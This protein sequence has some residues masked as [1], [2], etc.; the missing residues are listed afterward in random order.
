MSDVVTVQRSGT[1][2]EYAMTFDPET[3]LALIDRVCEGERHCS[4]SETCTHPRSRAETHHGALTANR[5][6]GMG[7]APA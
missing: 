1:D 2:T 4:R 3:V 7:I 5:W 6:N